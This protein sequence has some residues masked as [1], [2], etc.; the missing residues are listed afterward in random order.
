MP[1]VGRAPGGAVAAED[2]RNLKRWTGH[3]RRPLRRRLALPAL[4]WLL[5]RRDSRSS[6]LSTA[7]D[8]DRWRRARSAPWCP[9]Y[10]M[11]RAA[12]GLILMS[13]RRSQQVG[14]EAVAQRVQ[15]RRA[16]LIPAASAALVEQAVELAGR[17][18]LARACGRERA[19][20]SCRGRS[21]HRSVTWDAPSTTGAGGRASPAD[22]MTWRSLRPLDCSMRMIILRAVDMLD[23]QPH[24]LAGTQSAAIAETEQNAGS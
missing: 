11:A 9:T 13:A 4:S 2:V 20:R 1:G 3:E 15:R 21:A 16:F 7:G 14:R 18:R 5:A 19:R 23:L 8:H 6:G 17:H 22:S 24:H 10:R 12:P